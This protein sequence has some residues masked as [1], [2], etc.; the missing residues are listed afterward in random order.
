MSFPTA[1]DVAANARCPHCAPVHGAS[2]TH[3]LAVHTPLSEQ[4]DA[5]VQAFAVPM[6][7]TTSRAVDSDVILQ[8]DVATR[9]KNILKDVIANAANLAKTW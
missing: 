3:A 1:G 2:Q 7:I 4:F 5:V 8:Y 9:L 6:R